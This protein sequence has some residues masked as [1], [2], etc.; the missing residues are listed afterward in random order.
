MH[1][2]MKK[3]TAFASVAAM[4]VSG[5]AAG[6]SAIPTITATAVT[7]TD[8]CN[9][10][11]LHAEGSRLYDK[12]GNEVWLT[13]ANWF[14]FNCSEACPHYLWSADADDCLK[15]IADRGINIIRFPISTELIVSWMNGKP[16]PVSSFSCNTDPSYT[17]NA[18]FCE[19]DGKTPK[20]SMEVFDI[21]MQ[22]CKKYG[23]KAF[24]DIHS[25]HTDNSGH[26][27][28]LWYGKAGVTT[29]VWIESLVWLANKYSR[30]EEVS[31]AARLICESALAASA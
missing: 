14:G 30:S 6:F 9:D 22:K 28:N 26:N 18:D 12:N 20:N 11:W 1:N 17:I 24:I 8:D 10:D 4:S 29:D 31:A 23:I 7:A 13:G 2:F 16:N 5:A 15:E 21:M 19:A 27:Y 25:P 3:F